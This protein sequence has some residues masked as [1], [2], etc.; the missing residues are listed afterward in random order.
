MRS[1]VLISCRCDRRRLIIGILEEASPQMEPSPTMPVV[2]LD[3]RLHTIQV[4][5]R[6]PR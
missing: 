1:G 4:S 2:V 3:E 6:Q 5:A